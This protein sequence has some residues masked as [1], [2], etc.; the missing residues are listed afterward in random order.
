MACEIEQNRWQ[1]QNRQDFIVLEVYFSPDRLSDG[2][3]I[4]QGQ[5]YTIN[6]NEQNNS[7]I[8]FLG[9]SRKITISPYELS[10]VRYV[11][12]EFLVN[13]KD[14]HDYQHQHVRK[15]RIYM[16]FTGQKER[17]WK[18]LMEERGNINFSAC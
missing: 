11:Y 13:V 12:W 18:L 1:T 6:S 3:A 17:A 16:I 14:D 7:S 4:D 10:N 8:T 5:E 9:H 2:R 15:G